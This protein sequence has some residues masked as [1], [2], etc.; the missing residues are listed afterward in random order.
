MKNEPTFNVMG[1]G[2]RR[3]KLTVGKGGKMISIL[4]GRLEQFTLM[5]K[6]AHPEK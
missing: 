6:T 2:N 3:Y 1:C 4:K 5:I